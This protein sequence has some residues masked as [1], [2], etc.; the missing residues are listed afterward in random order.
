MRNILFCFILMCSISVQAQLIEVGSA[1]GIGTQMANNSINKIKKAFHT[2]EAQDIIQ[3]IKLEVIHFKM[4]A[5]NYY[6]KAKV[7]A[8]K[9][10]LLAKYEGTIESS[11]KEIVVTLFHVRQY[12]CEQM[13]Q[14]GAKLINLNNGKYDPVYCQYDNIMKFIF[15]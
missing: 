10:P 15:E 12:E 13:T 1:I 6:N 3:K 14:L 7:E 4:T 9:I 8:R 2:A 5:Q 11:A